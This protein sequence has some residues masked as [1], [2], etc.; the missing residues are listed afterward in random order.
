MAPFTVT[1]LAYCAVFALAGCHAL[2]GPSVGPTVAGPQ[3]PV[4]QRTA[5]TPD[6]SAVSTESAPPI[7]RPGEYRQLTS[8]D[9]QRL[10]IASAPF[11]DDLD[12]HSENEAPSHP[13]LMKKA[14][15]FA[16]VSCLVRGHA[17]DELRNR[18]AA[19]ALEEFFKLAEAEGQFDLLSA[20]GAE[21]RTQLA[22]AEQAEKVGLKD[23]ADMPALRRKLLDIEAQQ[24]KLEAGA[25]ALNASL[26]ARL[27]LNAND[28]L[29]LWPTDPL[30]VK[31][32]DVD[33]SLAVTTGLHYRPDLNALRVLTGHGGAGDMTNAVLTGINPLLANLKPDNPLVQLFSP[34][35]KEPAHQRAAVATRVAG[36]L[37]ARERQAEAEIRATATLLRGYRSA[38]AARALDVRAVEAR[39][40]ELQKK[41]AAGVNVAADLVTAKLDLFKARGDLLSSA[42]EW[43]QAEV[44]LRQA[45]GLLVREQGRY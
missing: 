34:F 32:D 7:Q 27:G 36:V 17:A 11:A 44:K 2:K 37:A 15:K 16:E 18:A 28:P 1:R 12:R 41:Q 8:A 40:V 9:C 19:E 21:L 24:S 20:A 22:D 13:K 23:R 25:G 33:V 30:K 35:A 10:A 31:P 45:M 38:V 4:T 43:H 26:R 42:I 14:A 29:P 6:V 5:I 39:I 3:L